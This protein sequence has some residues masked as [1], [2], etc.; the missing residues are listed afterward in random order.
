MLSGFSCD[1]RHHLPVASSLNRT[2][3]RGNRPFQR[4][5]VESLPLAFVGTACFRLLTAP[6]LQS[7]YRA[8]FP[9]MARTTGGELPMTRLGWAQIATLLVVSGPFICYRLS[10]T[11]LGRSL[12]AVF[13]PESGRRR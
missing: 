11:E 2:E 1:P 4:F 8:V 10:H 3:L 6:Q 5:A 7:L 12:T 13:E 9:Q